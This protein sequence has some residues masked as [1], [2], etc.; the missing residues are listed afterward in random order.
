MAVEFSTAC[1]R[2][3]TGPVLARRPCARLAGGMKK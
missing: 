1:M 2:A 3:S